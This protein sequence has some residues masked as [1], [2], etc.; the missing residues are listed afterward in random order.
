MP[1][2]YAIY[3]KLVSF[4]SICVKIAKR[5]EVILMNK[6][7]EIKGRLAAVAHKDSVDGSTKLRELGID[8]LDIVELLL[9]LEEDYGVH[10]DDMDMSA[11]VTVQDLL[12][13]IAKQL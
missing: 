4:Y 2:L 11:L 13:A 10:F 6:I 8:S 1:L 12:D 5:N 9:Q 7:E 3:N